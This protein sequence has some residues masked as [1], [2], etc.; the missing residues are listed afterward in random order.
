MKILAFNSRKGVYSFELKNFQ[1]ELHAHPVMEI[2]TASQGHF[3]L[4]TLDN[5]VVDKLTFAVIAANLKHQLIAEDC[6]LKLVM[7]EH[8]NEWAT[9]FLQAHGIVLQEGFFT[10]ASKNQLQLVD[11]L[12]ALAVGD[13][14]Q[15]DIYDDRVQRCLSYIND[16]EV[17]YHSMIG[18]LKSE[19]HLSD[20]RLSHLFRQEIGLSLKKYLVWSRLKKTIQLVLEQGVTLSSAAIRSGFYD[21]AHLSKAFKNMLGLSPSEAY[22]SRMLQE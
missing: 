22:N 10:T 15:K 19:V 11:E 16:R 6:E 2:I 14:C 7:L 20:S 9:T 3:S 5:K 4:K 1:T 17:A 8:K 18:E 21:Q 13:E 12:M